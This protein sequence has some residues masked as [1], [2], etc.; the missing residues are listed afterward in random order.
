MSK[1]ADVVLGYAK[2]WADDKYKEGP[3]NDT[4][5]GKWFGLNNQ[6]WCM[7]FVMWCLSA[8]KVKELVFRTAS[9]EALESWAVKNKKTVSPILTQAGDILLFDF[10]NEGKS[11]HTGF[12]TGPVDPKTHLIP[13]VEGNTAQDGAGSQANG[14][15]V[16]YKKRKVTDVR[17]VVRPEWSE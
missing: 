17:C 12:A 6:P 10:H 7:M 3:N 4:V 15:G 1:Q 16:Y 11:V 14:D 8:A 13:T 2:K 5:F 9:C